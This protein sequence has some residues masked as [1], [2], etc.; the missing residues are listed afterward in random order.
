M[1]LRPN[2]N[3]P[4]DFGYVGHVHG[5]VPGT[6]TVPRSKATAILHALR[7]TSGNAAYVVDSWWSL[8]SF[9]KCAMFSPLADGLLWQAIHIARK[10]RLSAGAGL[11]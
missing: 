4:D 6:H 9:K 5:Q 3:D 1:I 7:H 2:P 8:R 10:E 11:D